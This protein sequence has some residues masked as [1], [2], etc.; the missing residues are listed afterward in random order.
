MF[1]HTSTDNLPGKVLRSLLL[2]HQE[3]L[4]LAPQVDPFT[5]RRAARRFLHLQHLF[6]RS[7]DETIDDVTPPEGGNQYRTGSKNN[8]SQGAISVLINR[9]FTNFAVGSIFFR[10]DTPFNSPTFG[11]VF[12]RETGTF[13][14]LGVADFTAEIVQT[15]TCHVQTTLTRLGG[16]YRCRDGEKCFL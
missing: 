14:V 4:I 9:L 12:F 15:S 16:V 13:N 6:F 1:L 8:E 7:S 3:V 10:R 2:S 11:A 5:A